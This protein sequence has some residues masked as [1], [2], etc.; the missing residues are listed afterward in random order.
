MRSVEVQ[1]LFEE[2]ERS[3]VV[4]KIKEAFEQGHSSIEGE[5]VGKHGKRTLS[6]STVLKR[7]WQ[8]N[9]ASLVLV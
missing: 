2:K 5:L 8:A 4:Q 3:V 9:V 7:P 6:F 1:Y